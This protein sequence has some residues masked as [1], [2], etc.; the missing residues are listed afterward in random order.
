MGPKATSVCGLI[1]SPVF[2]TK[3][4]ERPINVPLMMESHSHV[5]LIHWSSLRGGSVCG[6]GGVCGSGS[7]ARLVLSAIVK[8]A[9]PTGACGGNN[10][11]P[12]VESAT[13]EWAM[14]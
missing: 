8:L 3:D 10:G 11:A 13:T 7:V 1:P 14:A 12:E 2:V 6:G 5:V 9:S 4:T